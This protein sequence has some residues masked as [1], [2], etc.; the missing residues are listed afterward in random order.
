MLST[1]EEIFKS[2]WGKII[3]FR[4]RL[5]GFFRQISKNHFTP[6]QKVFFKFVKDVKIYFITYEINVLKNICDN[7]EYGSKLFQL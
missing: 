6:S 3:K 2:T 1:N 4:F 5:T 7:L